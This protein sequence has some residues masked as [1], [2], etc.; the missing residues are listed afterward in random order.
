MGKAVKWPRRFRV[1]PERIGG[2]FYNCL[3][4]PNRRALIE[5]DREANGDRWTTRSGKLDAQVNYR[6]VLHRDSRGRFL[7][8][9]RFCGEIQMHMR[10]LTRDL[11]VGLVAH[12][13]THAAIFYAKHIAR[14]NGKAIYCGDGRDKDHERFCWI[15]G[16]IALQIQAGIS[17]LQAG[18]KKTRRRTDGARRGNR[19]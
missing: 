2:Y 3:I 10:G 5:Y 15:V 11:A 12:E 8:R 18:R 9:S 17:R 13:A 1:Y 6:C 4:F 7:G 19:D 16:H 14:L